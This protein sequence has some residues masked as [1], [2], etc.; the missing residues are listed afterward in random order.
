MSAFAMAALAPEL[1][2]T[3][4]LSFPKSGTS[5]LEG[6]HCSL[7]PACRWHGHTADQRLRHYENGVQ[8]G[9]EM[10]FIRNLRR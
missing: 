7:P 6:L 1:G 8:K 3:D 10:E 2:R 4:K 5:C 9:A